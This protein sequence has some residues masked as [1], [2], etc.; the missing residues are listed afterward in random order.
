MKKMTAGRFQAQCLRVM[1]EVRATG[2][3]VVITEH[4]RAL[5]KLVPAEKFLGRLQGIVT[6]KGDI[7][8]T[9]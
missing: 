3:P 9:H 2:E 8:T 6:I 4:G 1:E 5:V 7:G